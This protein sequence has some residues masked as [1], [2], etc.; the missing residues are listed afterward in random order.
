MPKTTTP[1]PQLI[2]NRVNRAIN[3]I[4]NIVWESTKDLEVLMGPPPS[5]EMTTFDD[6]LTF[7]FVKAEN[8]TIIGPAEWSNRWFKVDIPAASEE[9][10]GR[11]YLYWNCN[12][13]TTIF[14]NG[15]PWC[16]ID[17]GHP[18]APLPD[19]A[20]TLYLDVGT[21][22]T[23]MGVVLPDDL[24]HLG[25]PDQHG[26]RFH[27]ASI[28]VRNELAY[29]VLNDYQV[30]MFLMQKMM[31]DLNW[32]LPEIGHAR[33]LETAPPVL[34]KLLKQFD[35]IVDIVDSGSLEEVS[36]KFKEVYSMFPAAE[37]DGKVSYC[38]HS[39]LDLV[40]MWPESVTKRKSV[41]TF[42]T[43]LRLM[44]KYPEFIYQM[45][46]P[47]LLHELKKTQPKQY[48][49][50]VD[51][52][53]ENRWDATGGFEVEADTMMPVGEALGRCLLYGQQR[54]KEIKGDIT[55]TLWIPDVFGYNQ[56]L[57]QICV[58][59]GIKNFYTTKMTWSCV[60][61]FP[62]NSFVWQGADGSELL[63]HLANVCYNSD[64]VPGEA[65]ESMRNYA[66]ADV[67]DEILI[68][69]GY[70]DGAGGTTEGHME[71]VRRMSNLATVP[72]TSWT[73]VS[74]F[75]KRLD[76]VR[77]DLPV[78][79]GE[80]YLEYHRG[81][82]TTQADFKYLYRR[83]ERAMQTYEAACALHGVKAD[84]REDWLRIIFCQFH[85]AIPGSS[86]ELV[87]QDLN[88]ELREIG[89]S[90]FKKASELSDG[91]EVLI[92]NPLAV[93]N[94][95]LVEFSVDSGGCVQT[96]S[97]RVCPSQQVGDKLVARV[98]LEPLE[99]VNVVISSG[100]YDC[101]IIEASAR[102]M[103]NGVVDVSFDS[104]GHVDALSIKGD[105]MKLEAPI[106]FMLHDDQ[107]FMFDA[108]DIDHS[109][110]WM[111]REVASEM[112]LK[113]V[114]RGAA[115]AI[116][117]GY[118]DIGDNSSLQVDY[119]LEAG[120]PFLKFRLKVDW[121]EDHKL[122][123]MEVPTA[124]RNERARYGCPF[125]S[126]ERSQRPGLQGEETMWEVAGSRWMAITDGLDRGLAV[127]TEAKYGFGAKDGVVHLSLLRSPY[128]SD[129]DSIKHENILADQGEHDIEFSVGRF[130]TGI[131]G[132][133]STAANAESLYTKPLLS[134][135]IPKN[136][137]LFLEELA[138]VT[139]SWFKSL[140]NTDGYLVR[141]HETMGV[142]GE[143][144]LKTIESPK[145]VYIVD[146]FENKIGDVEIVSDTEF[147][148]SYNANQIISLAIVK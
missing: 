37:W 126:I 93:S 1:L 33:V 91:E 122:L 127:I 52:I 10:K 142:G 78:Y 80:L 2:P 84:N 18:T 145:D 66:Q 135:G 105:R 20:S 101:D 50:V 85:D 68:A 133:M 144:T 124:Y 134:K 125:G 100:S 59:G 27:E 25:A 29:S 121:H 6:A 65:I 107:P 102:G 143:F 120:L 109:A 72:K 115:F 22:Q 3:R 113:V 148:V 26:Y 60:T 89:D 137:P 47:Y 7:E 53:K 106:R 131:D 35:D 49:Q 111:K 4:K 16:G 114:E 129:N 116:V 82:L 23:G 64:S 56:C 32:N 99:S 19:E 21:Y 62:H 5:R 39:H 24:P 15:E 45:S 40:W 36:A 57:P 139:P 61:K 43:M 30:L 104:T 76:A 67:H 28:K 138:T 119:I 92:S 128:T 17:I 51:R 42:A 146:L 48:E 70:G 38:G 132:C 34:R 9:E 110:N 79:R 8:G 69:A 77:D 73:T 117:R 58:L 12:G 44:E 96:S 41:H 95:A 141:L 83:A 94:S 71:R 31:A 147:K 46:Q 140:D 14:I 87:Y 81:T 130:E 98:E 86:I 118:A 97:G 54:F 103:S 74:D 136:V 88:A 63:T 108:W 11:R 90:Y 13:E 55:D 123:R 112:K 75:F